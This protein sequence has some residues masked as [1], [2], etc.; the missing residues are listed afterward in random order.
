MSAHIRSYASIYAI[1]H[2]AAAEL[3]DGPVVVEEKIDGSQFSFSVGADGELSCR[4][5]G[6]D[7]VVD[8]PEKMFAAAVDAALAL[9]PDLRPGWVYR[10]EYLQKPKHSTLAYARI[11]ARHLILFDID[12]GLEEYLTPEQKRAEAA[13]VGLEAVPV[14]YEGVIASADV[15]QGLMRAESCLGGCAPEGLVVKNY[16]KFGADKKALMGKYVTE[17]FKESHKLA[18][19]VSNPSTKDVVQRLIDSY[20]TEARWRKSVQHL[21]ESGDL[22]GSPQDIGRLLKAV[23]ADVLKE[24]RDEIA[25]RLFAYAWPQIQRGIT[26][27]L[28]QWYKDELLRSAFDE[29]AP[30][31]APAGREEA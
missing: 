29:A 28:P 8:A 3:F 21:R 23:G 6:K 24:C 25:E 27:G 4:S 9:A 26:V 18:W 19:K 16:A 30:P 1:G 14:L 11:P 13:R 20:K 10:A 2:K 5:K 22:T 31:A 7:L 12:T 17:A 15:L